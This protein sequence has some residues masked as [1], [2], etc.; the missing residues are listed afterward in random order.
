MSE[1]SIVTILVAL[2]GSALL[3]SLI[4]KF[5]PK[6]ELDAVNIQ[7]AI[8][9]SRE[10]AEK[11]KALSAEFNELKANYKVVVEENERLED[12]NDDLKRENR[13]YQEEI[14][15]LKERVEKLEQEL[16]KG[17]LNEHIELRG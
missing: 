6:T 4:N 12:E 5:K 3:P 11:Y 16:E 8:E 13:Q 7:T 15:S 10:T 14:R 1:E 17:K 2:L 9:L